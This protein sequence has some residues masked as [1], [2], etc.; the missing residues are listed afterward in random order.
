MP[1]SGRLALESGV[2]SFECLL[3]WTKYALKNYAG[4]E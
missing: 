4:K 3:E 1:R 2:R